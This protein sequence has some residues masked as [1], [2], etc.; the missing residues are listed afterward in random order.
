MHSPL[1]LL[2]VLSIFSNSLI[3]ANPLP[4]PIPVPE[5]SAVNSTAACTDIR[6]ITARASTELPGEGIIGSL[7]SAIQLATSKSVT[8]TSVSYPALLAPYAPSV[9]SGVAA[10][11]ADIIAAV[12]ACPSQKIVLLGYSQGAECISDTLGGAGGG[13]LGTKTPAIDSAYG[14]HV[15]AAVMMGDPR[16]MV[17]QQSFHVGTC[18][19]NGLFPRSS[20]QS[21][22]AYS[23]IVKSY[24]DFGDPFCCSG[25]DTLAH[26]TYVTKYQSL[27]LSFV[28]GKIA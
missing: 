2:S 9:A 1:A 13:I 6:I 27:A 10:M 3:H 23:S 28:L 20:D 21:L 11:K 4:L 12:D 22:T 25:L 18:F 26:L 5:T 17:N 19:Q 16:Y 14:S 15:K 8:R 7:A 24:C